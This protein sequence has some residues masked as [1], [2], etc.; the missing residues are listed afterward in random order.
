MSC[1]D[2]VQSPCGLGRSKKNKDK[3]SINSADVQSVRN[4]TSQ[5]KQRQQSN[6]EYIKDTYINCTMQIC[7]SELE[8]KKAYCDIR[9]EKFIQSVFGFLLNKINL[10]CRKIRGKKMGDAQ[11]WNLLKNKHEFSLQFRFPLQ[12]GLRIRIRV[13]WLSQDQSSTILI[14][15]GSW[16]N[17]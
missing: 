2:D 13:V 11:T 4:T 9:T 14:W 5:R 17:I 6:S 16:L 7:I 1:L 10:V 15:S 8:D 3:L 12:P